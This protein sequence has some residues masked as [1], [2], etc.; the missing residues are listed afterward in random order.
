[1]ATV[2]ST[3]GIIP[4]WHSLQHFPACPIFLIWLE[5]LLQRSVHKQVSRKSRSV[6]AGREERGKGEV[7]RDGWID[8]GYGSI[9]VTFVCLWQQRC[10]WQTEQK[11]GFLVTWFPFAAWG[12]FRLM[13]QERGGG[14]SKMS[15]K[16]GQVQETHSEFSF[17]HTCI[18]GTT[19]ITTIAQSVITEAGVHWP[20]C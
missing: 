2:R 11:Q 7:K 9:R 17:M 6:C 5:R 10:T 19:A 18:L 4:R 15:A 12:K 8:E 3:H 13:E 14:C 20:A 16:P 1:M